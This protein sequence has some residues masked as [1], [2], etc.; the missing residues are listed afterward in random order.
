MAQAAKMA[1][2]VDPEPE[3]AGEKH[4]FR[5]FD[6]REKYLMF[7]TTC[8]EK[9]EVAQRVGREIP[10]LKPTPPALNLFD[11]GV[12]DGTV[13]TR[14][15]RNLHRQFPA[16]PFC[17][18]GKEISMEDVRLTLEKLP[19]RFQEHPQLVVV[20][21][22]LYYAESPWLRVNRPETKP[23]VKRWNIALEGS[24]AHEFDE[25]VRNLGPVLAEG[26]QTKTSEKTGNPLYVQPSI[27][28]L[29]RKDR[30]FAL[31]GV[32][33]P[34]G[35]APAGYDLVI[36]SQPYRARLSAEI[37]VRNVLGP[38]ARALSP[39]GR[40]IVIQSTGK[41]PGMELINA[42][43]EEE[44]PF[45]TPRRDLI[46]AMKEALDGS[47][48]DLNYDALRD[49]ES[50]F[51]YEL[52]A[53]P[54]EIGE[55]IGTSTLLAAWN[56]ATYV[57]QIEDDRMVDVLRDGDYLEAARDVLKR[58]GGL[59]FEDESFLVTRGFA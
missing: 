36:A 3:R 9:W 5:F 22:N 44:F 40:M 8:S 15:M 54:D 28:V 25:Q 49:D 37:K 19:D 48:N 58:Y 55:S 12:G 21:T 27:L 38:L 45:V 24:T 33:P 53:L 16:I 17:V 10:F 14:V 18:V 56:A 31:D 13:L 59:W 6:N 26:W 34:P 11:A 39:G 1:V 7:V 42:V 2:T 43:W 46:A 51:R 57:A 20:I 52:H 47:H 32:I 30:A 29:Y 50:L 41:D 4:A 23:A 35:G